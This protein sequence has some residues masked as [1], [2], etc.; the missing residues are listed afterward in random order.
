MMLATHV[1]LVVSGDYHVTRAHR[2]DL[3]GVCGEELGGALASGYDTIKKI[4]C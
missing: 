2:G 3:G 1:V 4:Y